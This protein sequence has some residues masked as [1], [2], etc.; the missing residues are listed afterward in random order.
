LAGGLLSV[1]Y[2]QELSS[3]FYYLGYFLMSVGG[4]CIFNSTYS[5]GELFPNQSAGIIGALSTGKAFRVSYATSN[6][7]RLGFFE[8]RLLFPRQSPVVLLP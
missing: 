4:P 5:F 8:V 6:V 3:N 1:A 2:A 7:Q